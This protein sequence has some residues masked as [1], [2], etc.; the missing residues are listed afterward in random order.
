MT[1]FFNKELIYNYVINTDTKNYSEYN[2]EIRNGT[3]PLNMLTKY[4]YIISKEELVK[5]HYDIN[6]I[7]T[8]TTCE[9][10]NSYMNYTLNTKGLDIDYVI[11]GKIK[12]IDSTTGHIELSPETLCGILIAQ[13][14]ECV[15]YPSYWTIRLICNLSTN[16][17]CKNYGTKLLG[18]YMNALLN[19]KERD[20]RLG[21]DYQK[22]G[23]LELAGS[24]TNL[25]G[26]CSYS[27]F[28]FVENFRFECPAFGTYNLTMTSDIDDITLTDV[29]NTVKE[30][31]RYKTNKS[32]G[33]SEKIRK[34]PICFY[35]N[36]RFKDAI[37]HKLQELKERGYSFTRVSRTDENE[38]KIIKMENKI[39][40][41]VVKE[42]LERNKKINNDRREKAKIEKE[43]NKLC[44]ELGMMELG[45]D[46]FIYRP[47]IDEPEIEPD[48]GKRKK[49]R[50]IK[51]KKS[52]KKT[53]SRRKV[54]SR[55]RR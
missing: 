4:Y 17:S 25:A 39:I 16:A 44:E 45:T 22:Y 26:Y 37:I 55:K 51:K 6:T 8:S 24:Y 15:T 20:I 31:T 35:E 7:I 47:P 2:E 28:G 49:T 21:L 46:E 54:K 34:R 40:N 38:R 42:D 9:Y 53:R 11:I 19:T 43:F 12:V 30:N 1:S 29:Y 18:L 41:D 48:S 32:T 23:V 50:S 14:G 36:T 5:S 33:V 13:K 27:K 3:I 52:R 10:L